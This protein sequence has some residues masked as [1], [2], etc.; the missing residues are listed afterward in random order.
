MEITHC[1]WTVNQKA[2]ENHTVF[3]EFKTALSSHRY[4]HSRK[5]QSEKPQNVV[6]GLCQNL[7]RILR[8]ILVFRFCYYMRK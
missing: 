6:Y 2:I 3:T 7:E 1:S 5:R 4:G 8:N